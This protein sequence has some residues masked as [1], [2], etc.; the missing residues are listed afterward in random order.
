MRLFVSD[1]GN[2]TL[3]V[4][5]ANTMAPLASCEI[6][7]AG[8]LC[9]WRGGV[10]CA[11]EQQDAVLELRAD[12]LETMRSIPAG[13]GIRVLRPGLDGASLYALAGD[14]DSL[15]KLDMAEGALAMLT[16][17]GVQP[18]DLAVEPGGRWL[19]VAGGASCCVHILRSD[20]LAAQATVDVG[21]IAVGVSFAP[22]ALWVLCAVGQ[23]EMASSLL[24]VR[25]GN[26]R[27]ERTLRLEG[28]PGGL[29]GL[30]DEGVLV[31]LLDGVVHV[32]KH[33]KR[34]TWR[35]PLEGALPENAVRQGAFTCWS[36]PLG[37]R[38]WRVHAA[39]AYAQACEID[40]EEPGGVLL[41]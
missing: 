39:S 24:R 37:G 33:G 27:V 12:T 28:M 19:A 18:R 11:A 36:D 5:D 1:A 16:R 26:W 15:L 35:I 13:P 3:G 21:G 22:G 34:A 32:A 2:G 6:P 9:A 31:G 4:Y 25:T 20:T 10:L 41:L 29:I 40:V 8:A 23:E 30:P 17:V 7:G 38:V 14:A